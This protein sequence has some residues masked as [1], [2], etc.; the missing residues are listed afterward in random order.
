M[1]T[2]WLHV[3]MLM[4]LVCMPVLGN[5]VSLSLSLSRHQFI[6]FQIQ[7]KCVSPELLNVSFC[8]CVTQSR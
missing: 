3:S 7:F 6:R 5:V 8:R 4:G 2:F 1:H